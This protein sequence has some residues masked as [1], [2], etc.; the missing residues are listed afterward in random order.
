M[1]IRIQKT[2]YDKII[3]NAICAGEC[4]KP[5]KKEKWWINVGKGTV[6]KQY[7]RVCWAKTK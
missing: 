1:K 3:E 4:R 7:C 2:P 5:L 6:S